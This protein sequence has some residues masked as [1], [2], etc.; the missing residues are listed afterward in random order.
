MSEPSEGQQNAPKN[1]AQ[2]LGDLRDPLLVLASVIYGVGYFVWSIHA[3]SEN[4]GLLPALEP[5]YLV[6]GIIPVLMLWIAWQG[7]RIP[8]RLTDWI[9]QRV[10]QAKGWQKQAR[11]VLGIVLLVGGY[12]LLSLGNKFAPV[13][14]MTAET[15][16]WQI[17][18]ENVCLALAYL[19]M[20]PGFLFLGA[21]FF[22]KVLMYFVTLV[23]ASAFLVGYVFSIYPNIPQEFGGVRPR[24]A[25]VDITRNQISDSMQKAILPDAPPKALDLAMRDSVTRSIRLKT[26]FADK[27]I[28]L[29]RPDGTDSHS[30][31][32]EIKK[33]VVQA[34]TW[35]D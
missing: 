29:V 35:C 4:L 19:L 31:I 11:L 10:A 8:R 14:G 26:Y 2:K 17:L 5:Q 7:R 25:Y 34:I 6:A 23:Y 13:Q 20:V 33:S 3:Y 22:A 27:E 21:T 18:K 12:Y 32:I 24:C 1:W 16:R 9:S 28:M 30:P 15:A